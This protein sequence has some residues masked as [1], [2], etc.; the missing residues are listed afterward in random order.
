MKKRKLVLAALVLLIGAASLA[1]SRLAPPAQAGA[2][3]LSAQ[4]GS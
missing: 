3:A 1:A 2:M 4:K